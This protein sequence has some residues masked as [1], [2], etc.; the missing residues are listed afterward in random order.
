MELGLAKQPLKGG[1]RI[2]GI[3]FLTKDH[4]NYYSIALFKYHCVKITTNFVS[5]LELQTYL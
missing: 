1:G 5:K 3:S 4:V 2:L